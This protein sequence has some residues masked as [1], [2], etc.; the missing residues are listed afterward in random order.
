[1]S[2]RTERTP[3]GPPDRVNRD[4]E[5]TKRRP[6]HDLR[7]AVGAVTAWVAAAFAVSGSPA[8]AVGIAVVAALLGVGALTL[9]RSGRKFGTVLAL[10]AFCVVIVLAPLAARLFMTRASPLAQLATHRV[11]VTAVVTLTGDARLL[12][13]K[14]TAGSPRAIVDADVE[15]LLVAGRSVDARGSVVILAP[16]GVWAGLQPGQRLR[17]DAEVQP[18]LDGNLLSATLVAES[19]PQ[20]IGVPP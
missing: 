7:L 12:A 19:D 20:L 5:S 3:S 6:G 1:M 18:A 16:A 10:A 15:E 4:D 8:R 9:H 2:A 11:D 13:A 17:I 14:G